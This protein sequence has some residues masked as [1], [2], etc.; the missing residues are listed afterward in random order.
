MEEVHG[1]S[2]ASQGMSAMVITV[3]VSSMS[4]RGDLIL[5]RVYAQFVME[6]PAVKS[7][8]LLF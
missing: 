7:E 8:L 4:L 1:V 5:L 2:G 6:L 3:E